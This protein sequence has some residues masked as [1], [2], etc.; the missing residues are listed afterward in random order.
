M[1]VNVKKIG[2]K[3]HVFVEVLHYDDHTGN[4]I[5]R[6]HESDIRNYVAENSKTK[7][8]ECI[9]NDMIYNLSKRI[10][11]EWVF[12]SLETINSKRT[13]VKKYKKTQKKLDNPPKDVIIKETNN[14]E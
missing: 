9:K 12:E 1:K 11:G 7:L 4:K 2:K 5:I 10:H 13:N 14:S 8:G 6:L 3:I